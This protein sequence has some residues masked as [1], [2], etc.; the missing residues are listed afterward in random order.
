MM[1]FNIF[2]KD[3]YIAKKI[4]VKEDK[5]GNDYAVYD[6]PQKYHFNVQPVVSDTELNPYGFSG[7]QTMRA[8]CSRSKYE[9]I[10]HEGDV[11]YIDG[12][13]PDDEKVYGQKANYVIK[14]NP[15][16][17]NLLTIIYF[18]KIIK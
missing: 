4:G 8:I 9:N 1:E 11:A 18:E 17:Q 16:N 2:G 14:G 6:E 7:T 5:N 15:L 3:I 12:V 10:F 13:T